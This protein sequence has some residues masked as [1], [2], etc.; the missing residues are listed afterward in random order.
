LK[1]GFVLLC[2]S[3]GK[4]A[5]SATVTL[6]W[7]PNP[8]SNLAGYKVQYG[9]A[10]GLHPTTIDVGKQTTY[11]VG[12]LGP[13][14]YYFVVL[15]YNTSGLQSPLSN[16]VSVTITGPPVA[17]GLVAAFSFNEGGGTT[18]NDASGNSNTGTIS[19]ASR[20]ALGRFGSALSF[21][22][23]NDWVTINSSSSMNLTASMTLEAWVYPA[24]APSGW[25]SVIGKEQPGGL[26]Y[27]LYASSES[28]NR[29]ATVV[30]VGGSNRIL[31]GGSQLVAGSWI[32]LAATYD[33]ATQRLYVNGS[34]VASRPQSGSI[35]TSAGPVRLGGNA[36]SGEFFRG[37]IDEVRIYNRALTQAEILI[38]MNA[39]IGQ[40]LDT[41]PPVISNGQPSG[42]LPAGTTQATLRVTTD[43]NATCRYA[44]TTGVAYGAMPNTF[45]TTGGTGHSTVV[46]SLVAG[47]YSFF[48]RCRDGANNVNPGDFPISF[49]IGQSP[50]AGLVAA[51][52]FNEASGSTVQ[53]ASGNNLSGTITG[54]TRTASGK[55]GRALTFNGTNSWVTVS[56]NSLL[57]LTTG[58]T[59][60]AWVF[61]TAYKSDWSNII[62]RER[63]DGEVY[64]LYAN[65]DTNVPGVYV[66]RG[67]APT[68]PL[69]ARGTTQ[70]PLNTWT[71]LAA[72]YDNTTLRLYVNGVQVGSRA[73]TGALLTSTG[74][75]R[76]GG[77]SIWGEFFTGRIDEVRV[78]SRA[79]SQV[80]IQN[81]MTRMI[82]P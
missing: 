59:L 3:L 53:D 72:T 47:S 57:N 65:I 58:M 73:L 81:D 67:S 27:S 4:S 12:G 37:L 51:Y 29:P 48:V 11:V 68:V 80:E 9:T 76:I 19:G 1:V 31:R 38:D 60:E 69:D 20:T 35:Q 66:V 13:G 7:N 61:P 56:A 2:L 63:P 28:S 82:E 43:E 21:D 32:H 8:E 15:A 42:V 44:T 41:T 30:S 24:V 14:T 46:N 70:V 79:L 62:I 49:S 54:A 17:A 18:I 40:T 33:G 26:A 78:Y 22:G 55:F 75:L 77:N 39:P 74:V 5:F 23:V 10:P 6:T 52:G 25:R 50:A 34:Q 64:N 71:H 36:V 16:E 45:S